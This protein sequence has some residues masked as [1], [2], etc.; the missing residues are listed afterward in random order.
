[1]STINPVAPGTVITLYQGVEWDNSNKNIR[2]FTSSTQRTSYLSSHILLSSANC[3]AVRMAG[4]VRVEAQINAVLTANYMS[5]RNQGIGIPNRDLFAFITSV[6]YV[7]VNTIEITFEMDWIQSFLFSFTFETCYVEREHVNDDTPGKNLVD[8]H[9]EVGEYVIMK[10]KKHT[11]EA[12][13]I[14]YVLTDGVVHLSNTNGIASALYGTGAHLDALGPLADFLNEYNDKPEYVVS[15]TMCATAMLQQNFTPVSFTNSVTD[16]RL[17]DHFVF[18]G[19][20]Y[21]P[22]NNKLKC[23]PYQLFTVDNFNGQVQQ[24]HW[25]DFVQQDYYTFDINGT[26]YPKPCMEMV[27]KNYKG[28]PND[29]ADDPSVQQISVIY[30]NFPQVGWASDTFRAWVSQYGASNVASLGAS[31]AI[32]AL[33]VAGQAAAGNPTAL[34]TAAATLSTVQQGIQTYQDYKTHELHGRQ[35]NGSVGSAGLNFEEERIGF[36]VTQYCI[37]PEMAKR[38]DQYMTRF[39]YRVDATKVP[40]ITG[41]AVCNYVKTIN[42]KVGGNVPVDAMRALEA[43][44]DSGTTFWHTDAIGAPVTDNPIV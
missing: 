24:Y 10:Q 5:F 20:H 27:P 12:G 25:E 39:G 34:A 13:V 4:K 32:S 41:R 14:A 26:P 18:Q 17:Y 9:L 15:L 22:K 2:W 19:E 6:D 7:N 30:D 43:A 11:Y 38:I 8:E 28:Q 37:K 23:Y 36:R 3:T 29:A 16:H 33:A 21:Y 44:M 40:N 42:A 35:M 1:M 31:V